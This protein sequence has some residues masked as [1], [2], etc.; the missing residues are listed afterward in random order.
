MDGLRGVGTGK[1]EGRAG[2][3]GVLPDQP[4]SLVLLT[5][6]LVTALET[7]ENT[8]CH[9]RKAERTILGRPPRRLGPGPVLFQSGSEL[10]SDGHGSARLARPSHRT[11]VALCVVANPC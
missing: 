8:V 9:K 11:R 10:G 5:S 4:G 3:P 2:G 7:P 6:S 1:Q